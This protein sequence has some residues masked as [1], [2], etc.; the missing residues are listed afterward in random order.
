MKNDIDITDDQKIQL[1]LSM[2]K[3]NGY[4]FQN[5][6]SFYNINVE[7]RAEGDTLRIYVA[8]TSVN[9]WLSRWELIGDADMMHLTQVAP[10]GFY[11][12]YSYEAEP[13]AAD[14]AISVNAASYP[15]ARAKAMSNAWDTIYPSMIRQLVRWTG[16]NTLGSLLT[17]DFVRT[18]VD[19]EFKYSVP[20]LITE[21]E[22]MWAW[23]NRP[24]R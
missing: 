3:N 6:S 17:A 12:L 23:M 1:L 19:V 24:R 5:A 2:I 9:A 10:N 8:I 14:L 22:I 13:L 7:Y 4:E 15:D 21:K 11:S 20:P 16:D 18:H